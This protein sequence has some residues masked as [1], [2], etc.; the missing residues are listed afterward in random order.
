MEKNPIRHGDV[1]LHPVDSIPLDGLKKV[2]GATLA[3]GTATGHSHGLTNAAAA[4]ISEMSDGKG[5]LLVVLERVGI[6]H[7]KHKTIMLEPGFYRVT[8]K[9][10]YDAVLGQRRVED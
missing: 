9:R 10:Q 5:R 6:Q 8:I 7:E 1:V 2:S 4:S 3:Q